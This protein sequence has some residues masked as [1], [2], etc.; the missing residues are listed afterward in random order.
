[1]QIL[2]SSGGLIRLR[3]FVVNFVSFVGWDRCQFA[4]GQAVLNGY[5]LL[6][7]G[8]ILAIHRA[9]RRLSLARGYGE[10]ERCN[11]QLRRLLHNRRTRYIEAQDTED[12][13]L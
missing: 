8:R 5:A 12:S 3:L 6:R 4:N 13:G 7:G 2:D 10:W 11:Q 9:R 1:V